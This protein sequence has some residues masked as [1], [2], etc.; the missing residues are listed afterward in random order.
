VYT[1]VTYLDEETRPK[2]KAMKGHKSV[3]FVRVY[4]T[5]CYC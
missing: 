1:T 5:T 3:L 2:E 4:V